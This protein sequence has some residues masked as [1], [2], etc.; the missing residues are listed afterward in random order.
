M[1]GA[2]TRELFGRRDTLVRGSCV[3]GWVRRLEL[4]EEP[5]LLAL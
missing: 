3:C 2:H 1:L 4:A 5:R